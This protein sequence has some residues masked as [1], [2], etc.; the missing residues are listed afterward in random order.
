MSAVTSF[1]ATPYTFD[2]VGG[3]NILAALKSL[4]HSL[5]ARLSRQ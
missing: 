3:M 5:V 4:Y 1:S 2:A